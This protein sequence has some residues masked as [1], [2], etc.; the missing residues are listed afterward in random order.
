MGYF[1][2]YSPPGAPKCEFPMG[3][4]GRSPSTLI[5]MADLGPI[6][7]VVGGDT[8]RLQWLTHHVTSQWPNAQVTTAPAEDPVSLAGF[9]QERAPDAVIL[10][11]DFGDEDAALK[12]LGY[13]VQMLRAQPNVY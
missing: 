11:V 9:V 10:Q 2:R 7:V 1:S 12:G 13:V 5:G 4:P 3:N 8:K 6:L